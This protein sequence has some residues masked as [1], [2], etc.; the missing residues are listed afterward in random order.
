MAASSDAAQLVDE[1]DD[2][3]ERNRPLTDGDFITRTEFDL[4]IKQLM[5]RFVKILVRSH[6]NEI[7]NLEALLK[8]I[9]Q[10]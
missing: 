8:D 4:A 3:A 6:K 10:H 9:L 5:A 2:F 7:G 1:S